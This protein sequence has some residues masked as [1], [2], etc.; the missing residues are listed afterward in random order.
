MKKGEERE[1]ERKEEEGENEKRGNNSER[2]DD[3]CSKCGVMA[4][5]IALSRG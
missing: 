2:E 3:F 5:L 4:E 1:S